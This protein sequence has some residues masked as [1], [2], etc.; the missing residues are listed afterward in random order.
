MATY[1]ALFLDLSS[2]TTTAT[3]FNTGNGSGLVGSR[4]TIGNT[5]TTGTLSVSDSDGW[6][7]DDEKTQTLG[8]TQVLNGTSYP[9]SYVVDHEYSFTVTDGTSTWRVY[10]VSTQADVRS[11]LNVVGFVFAGS[12]PP[13]GVAL[14]ISSVTEG[15]SNRTPYSGFAA[16]GSAP[17]PM[18]FAAGTLI[19]TP[20]GKRPVESLKAG[21]LVVTADGGTEPVLLVIDRQLRFQPGATGRPVRIAQ[22]ALG[23]GLPER[24][25]ILSPQHRV[26]L[27]AADG[28]AVLGP[29]GGLCGLPG[30]RQMLGL[31]QVRYLHLLLPRHALILAEGL[32]TESLYGGDQVL[33]GMGPLAAALARGANTPALPFLTMAQTRRLA[34]AMH[35]APRA[36]GQSTSAKSPRFLPDAFNARVAD[37]NPSRSP[38]STPCVSEVS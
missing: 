11:P 18:C 14:T 19:A 20:D 9:G 25:L 29:A 15:D 35:Q 5:A 16:P 27:W 2:V 21:D 32:V 30:V 13:R 6:F 36:A 4:F 34:Q 8:T 33:R 28:S 31:R 38:S 37:M 17:P 1:S 7:D 23:A 26:R 3:S 12:M 24:P 10:A 22:S